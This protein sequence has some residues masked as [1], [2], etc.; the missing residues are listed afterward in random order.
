MT[1]FAE[2]LL[3]ALGLIGLIMLPW[4]MAAIDLLF[5]VE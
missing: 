1:R 5:S 3:A 4:L 2:F